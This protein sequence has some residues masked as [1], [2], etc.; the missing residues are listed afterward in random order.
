MIGSLKSLSVVATNSI[1]IKYDIFVVHASVV[2]SIKVLVT[3][4]I[5]RYMWRVRGHFTGLRK[6]DIGIARNI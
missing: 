4:Y 6:L 1:L 2:H 3:L 5:S